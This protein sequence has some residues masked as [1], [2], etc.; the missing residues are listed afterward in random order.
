MARQFFTLVSPE[1]A[2]QQILAHV[3]PIRDSETIPTDQAI[4]RVLAQEVRSPQTL[5]EFRR[6]T[7]DGFAVLAK[8]TYG[9]SDALPAYLRVM[10][11]VPMGALS[12]LVLRPAEAITVHTGGM[13]PEGADAVVMIENTQPAGPDEI[14]VRRS[15]APGENVIG[16]GEDIREGDLIL[17]AGHRLREQDLGGLL[18]VGLTQAEVVRQPLVA[19]FATGDEVIPPGQATHPGQVRDINSYTIEALARRAGARTER[20]GILPDDFDLIYAQVRQA[21]DDG[22]DMIVLS[23]GSSISVRD[24]TA[25]VFNRLGEPGVLVHGIATRPGKPT[26]LGMAGRVPTIGLPGNPVSA[27]VQFAMVCTPVLYALQGATMPSA[28][29]THLPLT[30]NVASAAGR[31]DYLPAR[32]VAGADGLMADPVFF[33]SNLIFSLVHADGLIRIPLD[34]TGM[35]AGERIE[36]RLF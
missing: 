20:R 15:A 25:D 24:V 19:I 33:K 14:E 28:L 32:L 18:A 7:V 35:D 5:P 11:E 6:A 23:A 27:F 34:R 26:I 13:V 16:I 1:E 3:Q 22:V 29:T 21:Y 17:P 12:G 2:R 4:G 31:E 10:G 30:T 36:M 9:A 8:N